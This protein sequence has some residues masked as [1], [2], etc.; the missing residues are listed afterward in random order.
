MTITSLK[1]K[2]IKIALCVMLGVVILLIAIFT[3]K[4]QTVYFG[5]AMRRV[6]IYQVQTTEKVCALTFDAAW[7]ADKTQGILDILKEKN[8]GG[9]FFLVGF[10][11]E[12]Y[13]DMIKKIDEQGIEI[14]TH[15]NTHPKMSTLNEMQIR[16]ELEISIKYITDITGKNVTLFRPPFGDYNDRLINV[17]DSMGL[18]AIQWT[19]DT[20]D[21]KGI[22]GEEINSRVRQG[23][24]PG[25]IIL[26]HNNSDHVL[27]ALPDMIDYILSQGYKIVNLSD[28]LY[29]DNY[30]VDNNG[31]QIKN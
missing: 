10:W 5:Y 15:S 26:M 17:C 14:G 22:S 21:W 20:L 8:V 7:G 1:A 30:T 12:K 31:I 19:V 13:G 27:D 24:C 16:N 25:A 2:P 3:T 18:K 6:P 4:A 28:M 29:M 9:T 23:L 11:S